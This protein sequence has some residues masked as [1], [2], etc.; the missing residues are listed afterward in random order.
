MINFLR[1]VQKLNFNPRVEIPKSAMCIYNYC[2]SFLME[3]V[4][5]LLKSILYDLKVEKNK[6]SQCSF[7]VTHLTNVLSVI[8]LKLEE[9][10]Q[11]NVQ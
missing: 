7:R 10:S 3:Y 1:S 9:N 6:Q 11:R 5:M 4:N 2:F 8:F